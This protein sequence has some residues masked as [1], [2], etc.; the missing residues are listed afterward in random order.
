MSSTVLQESSIGKEPWL[1]S[2]ESST[3]PCIDGE[4]LHQ[5]SR[6]CP[7]GPE[8]EAA[9]SVPHETSDDRLHV[10]NLEAVPVI[11]EVTLLV[12]TELEDSSGALDSRSI[13][14]SF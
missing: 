4:P 7:P 14:P 1:V 12:T 11:A 10:V 5:Q 6:Y 9:G 3:F 2:F 8:I 13:H